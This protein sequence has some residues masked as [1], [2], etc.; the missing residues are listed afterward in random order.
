M[1]SNL[2]KANEGRAIEKERK[3]TEIIWI[4]D[5][6]KKDG[7]DEKNE[8]AKGSTN[9]LKAYNILY[10]NWYVYEKDDFVKKVQDLKNNWYSLDQI[11]EAINRKC[12]EL[13]NKSIVNL[14]KQNISRIISSL[15]ENKNNFRYTW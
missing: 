14:H 8:K 10:I 3:I 4:I 2:Q 11:A 13:D 7:E 6:W 15:I 1:I 9:F 12:E 5:S